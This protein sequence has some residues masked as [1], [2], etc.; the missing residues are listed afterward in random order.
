MVARKASY[1]RVTLP[2]HNRHNR[3]LH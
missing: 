1:D 3:V 2:A